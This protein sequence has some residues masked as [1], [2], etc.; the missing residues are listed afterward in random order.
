VYGLKSSNTSEYGRNI[1]FHRILGGGKL[2]REYEQE[3]EGLAQESEEHADRLDRQ[4]SDINAIGKAVS[5]GERLRGVRGSGL[6]SICSP[7]VILTR[8]IA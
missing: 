7:R 4:W 8:S 5:G 1:A 2:V 3:E 6:R